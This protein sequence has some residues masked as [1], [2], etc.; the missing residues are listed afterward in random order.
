MDLNN[1]VQF[2]LETQIQF[3][4][5]HWQTKSFARHNAFG[6]IY[7]ALDDLID[8]FVEVFMGK[9]GRFELSEEQKSI[10]IDNLSQLN[11]TEFIKTTKNT[12]TS[13]NGSLDEKDTDLINIRDEMLAEVNKLAYL[14]TLK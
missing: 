12:L 2:L 10:K 6:G 5:C 7:D 1:A 11:L 13:F 8:R 9:Y 4:I 3:K 14:L